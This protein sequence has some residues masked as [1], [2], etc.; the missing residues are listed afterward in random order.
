MFVS[1]ALSSETLN[2]LR[3]VP[4]NRIGINRYNLY[5]NHKY[6]NLED[7]GIEYT[8]SPKIRITMVGFKP[9][10]HMLWLSQRFL[11]GA[12]DRIVNFKDFPFKLAQ[13]L[14][15]NHQNID[16]SAN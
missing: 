12:L 15:I 11:F 2:Y 9:W 10:A 8:F 5:I 13:N 1:C 4:P 14:V 3:G 16:F 6:E 7:N